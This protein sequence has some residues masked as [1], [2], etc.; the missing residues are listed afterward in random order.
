MCFYE[1]IGFRSNGKAICDSDTILEEI[2]QKTLSSKVNIIW[3]SIHAFI[4]TEYAEKHQAN[5]FDYDASHL[6]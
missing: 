4:A 3:H 1:H 5:I 2:N 6:W